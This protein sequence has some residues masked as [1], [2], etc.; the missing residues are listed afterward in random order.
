MKFGFVNASYTSRSTAVADQECINLFAETNEVEGA[1]SQRSYYGTAGLAVFCTFPSNPT[2]GSIEANG[3]MFSV[4]DTTLYEVFS[5]GTFTAIGDVDSDGRP[6]SIAASN[7]QLLIVSAGRAFCFTLATNTLLEVTG[8]LAA[9]PLQVEYSDGYFIVC[10][11]SSNKFQVSD[12]LDGTVWPGIQ[13]NAV[14]VFPENVIS[15]I[16]NHRELWVM[17]KRHIQP[18]ANTGSDE[19]FDPIGGALMEIGTAATFARNRIDNTIFWIS[20]DERGARQAWRASGYTPQR[21]STH[22][23]ETAWSSYPTLETAVSYA[24]QDAGH[25][26]WVVYIPN[27]DCTWVFDVAENLWH[28]RAQW[29]EP[30]FF[31]HPSWNHVYAF[32]KHLV[33]DW[34]TGKLYDMSMDYLDNAGT[35]I[36]RL[37]RSPT[38][39]SEMQYITHVSLTVDFDTGQTPQPPFVDGNGN[40][41]PAQ[42]M[43]RWSDDRGKTWSNEHILGCGFAGEY[44]TRVIWWR[45]GVS[46]YR[47]Y[48]LSMTDPIPWAVVDSYLEVGT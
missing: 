14:S 19:I 30:N 39:G 6:A 2:R 22:A 1:Q 20:E 10:F 12:I 31:P 8:L 32:G 48:E 44:R 28:K 17:G 27:T 37:R 41:R 23:V 26:F 29:V 15:I 35:K 13:V 45:L 43:L 47:I 11:Q 24:Y 42:A 18:Y 36:R 9:V 7:I 16:V 4:C 3:R 21:I 34:Q 46:R 5:D 33:G 38:L 25:L 40:P